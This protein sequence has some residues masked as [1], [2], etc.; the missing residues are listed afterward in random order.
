MCVLV[1]RGCAGNRFGASGEL[2]SRLCGAILDRLHAKRAIA[3]LS[4]KPP[5][6]AK[7]AE[8]K[9]AVAKVRMDMAA[10]LVQGEEALAAAQ[11]QVEMI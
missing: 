10:A 1:V 11:T 9:P 2:Q 6:A 4:Q 7:P 5:A 3:A 8:T